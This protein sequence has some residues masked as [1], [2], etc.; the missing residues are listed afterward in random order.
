MSKKT[1]QQT[2]WH[3]FADTATLQHTVLARLQQYAQE[4][5]LQR[6]RFDLVLAGG[7][8]PQAI[9]RECRHIATDWS[10]WHLYFGD[11]RCL[12]P[13]HPERNSRMALDAWLA[14]VPIPAN[15]IH[16]I[17]A[18]LGATAAAQAYGDAL[19][20]VGDFDFVLLGLGED[21]HTA[22]LFPGHSWGDTD[23][24]PDVLAV[25]DA[26]KPPPERV[27]LSARRLSSARKVAFVVTG[28]GKRD[29]VAA[30]RAGPQIHAHSISPGDAVDIFFE[31]SL[32]A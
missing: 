30:W 4:A 15:Q 8:T 13:E 20:A 11:E 29:A 17:P 31:A 24:S 27:S 19:Q 7:T 25:F 18:E 6:G 26:P 23:E 2:Q 1:P 5:I 9:Y 22:S 28:Q 21:G 32:L 16:A 10:C 12:P 3:A 14:H